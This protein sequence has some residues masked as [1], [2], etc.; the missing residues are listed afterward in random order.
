MQ[1]ETKPSFQGR[2]LNFAAPRT[3]FYRAA[4]SLPN[5]DDPKIPASSRSYPMR[6]KYKL[7]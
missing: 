3:P 2:K 1:S 5:A 7:R 4:I 6:Y